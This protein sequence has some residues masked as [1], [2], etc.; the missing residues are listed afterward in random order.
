[1]STIASLGATGIGVAGSLTAGFAYAQKLGI[2][3]GI[4]LNSKVIDT[5]DPVSKMV[6]TTANIPVSNNT[7]FASL[8]PKTDSII[9]SGPAS[10]TRPLS[11]VLR[12]LNLFKGMAA[13]PNAAL[14]GTTIIMV[15]FA[16][17]QSV[18]IDQFVAIQTARPK[19]EAAPSRKLN[20]RSI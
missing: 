3:A 17:I 16:I 11:T 20:N 2:D 15:A 7:N 13:A 10:H 6:R 18:A 5:V 4:V 1:M 12:P 14:A 9:L 19:L 8:I